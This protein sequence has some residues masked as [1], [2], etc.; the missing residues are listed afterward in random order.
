MTMK[1]QLVEMMKIKAQEPIKIEIEKPIVDTSKEPLP[2]GQD[3]PDKLFSPKNNFGSNF[4]SNI[5]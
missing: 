2:E 1:S 4:A 3:T 5:G